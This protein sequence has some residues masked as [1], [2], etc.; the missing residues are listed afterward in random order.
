MCAKYDIPWDFYVKLGITVNYDNQPAIEGT[1]YDYILKT[2][3]GWE[4]ND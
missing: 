1:Q 3:F 4:F 2:G